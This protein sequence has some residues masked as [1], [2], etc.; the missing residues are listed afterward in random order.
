MIT[1]GH[2]REKARPQASLHSLRPTTASEE[3]RRSV[4][5][6]GRFQAPP[7]LRQ[8]LHGVWNEQGRGYEGSASVAGSQVPQ[9]SLRGV[10]SDRA[11]ACSSPGRELEKQR[12]RQSEDLVPELPFATALGEGTTL[13]QKAVGEGAW[14]G[15]SLGVLRPDRGRFVA[16]G[17]RRDAGTHLQLVG[18]AS[19]RR[20][21]GSPSAGAARLVRMMEIT[22]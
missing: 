15:R 20:V 7:V 6:L 14:T 21:T 2:D 18:Q 5:G 22:A 17:C 3:D 19:A 10:R 8:G 1:C 9:G 16:R 4:G 12:S 11:P 13:S